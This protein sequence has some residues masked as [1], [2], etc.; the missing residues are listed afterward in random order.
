MRVFSCAMIFA[1]IEF[2]Q[3]LP[4][5]WSK[6]QCVLIRCVMGSAPRSASALVICGRDTPMPASIST[7]PSGPVRTATLPPDPSSTLIL[8]RSLWVTIGETAALSLMRLTRPRASANAA[9][10]VSHAPVAAKA[11]PPTQQRQ[12]PRRDIA[13]N[14]SLSSCPPCGS[15]RAALE[16]RS[17]RPP[18]KP[19]YRPI[20]HFFPGSQG[21]RSPCRSPGA[22]DRRVR[23]GRDAVRAAGSG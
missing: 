18:L 9:R 13:E 8:L 22:S 2:S 12:K 14:A 6:C 5:V 20:V 16:R 15:L 4:S 10:G 17:H 23:S 21:R 19:S 11:A 1:P 3:A 7:L